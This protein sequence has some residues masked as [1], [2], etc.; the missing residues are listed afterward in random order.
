V[1]HIPQV[2]DVKAHLKEIMRSGDILLTLGAG[3]VWKAGESFMQEL[4]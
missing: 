3:D 4:P 1:A 2:D